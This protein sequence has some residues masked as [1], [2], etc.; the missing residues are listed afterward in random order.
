MTTKKIVLIVGGVVVVLTFLVVCFA[1]GIVGFA[2]YQVGNSDAAAR[3]RD[4]LRN[5]EKLQA[6]TGPVKDFGSIVTGSVNLHN[7]NGDATL[8]LKVIG[9]RKI[10][11]ATVDLVLVRG[12]AWRVSSASYV[13]GAGQ[14]IDLLDPYDTK[15]LIPLLVA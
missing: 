14:T 13:N 7:G 2:L 4:F 5:S 8:H 3:A 1:A 15:K 12:G 6:E 9:D 11:N 10:V